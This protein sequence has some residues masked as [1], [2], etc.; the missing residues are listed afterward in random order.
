MAKHLHTDIPALRQR[1]HTHAE[2]D[3]KIQACLLCF[4]N[5]NSH[6]CL[7]NHARDFEKQQQRQRRRR[8]RRQQQQQQRNEEDDD[9]DNNTNDDDDYYY[10]YRYHYHHY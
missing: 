7:L 2:A 5:P 6:H 3:T 8:R 1:V 10:H 9:G 4:Q